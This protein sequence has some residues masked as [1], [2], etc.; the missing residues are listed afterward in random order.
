MINKDLVVKNDIINEYLKKLDDNGLTEDKEIELVKRGIE[1]IKTTSDAMNV[2]KYIAEK[3]G[4][5]KNPQTQIN[6]QFNF[7]DVLKDTQKI[8]K[9]ESN[10]LSIN[11]KTDVSIPTNTDIQ[12]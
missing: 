1:L 11:D 7:N 5:T 3:R 8:D 6:N 4:A 10:D 12:T 2:A 9:P